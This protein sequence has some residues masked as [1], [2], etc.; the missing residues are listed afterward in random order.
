MD[1]VWLVS[2][3]MF[4]PPGRC[5]IYTIMEA[6]GVFLY[7]CSFTIWCIP[8]KHN[9]CIASKCLVSQTGLSL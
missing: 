3:A 6:K 4:A 5:C 9:L 7:G 8:T 2:I 1:K